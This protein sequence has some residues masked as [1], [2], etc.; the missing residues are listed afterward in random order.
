MSKEGEWKRYVARNL[1]DWPD[2]EVCSKRD[3]L[4]VYKYI[5]VH[6]W[7]MVVFEMA[8]REDG[9]WKFQTRISKDANLKDGIWALDG[10]KFGRIPYFHRGDDT[11]SIMRRRGRIPF[12]NEPATPSHCV[13]LRGYQATRNRG[14]LG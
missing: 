1:N 12:I 7:V 10:Y 5:L 3:I 11:V 13:F 9:K 8:P 4:L 14:V 6:E 2:P